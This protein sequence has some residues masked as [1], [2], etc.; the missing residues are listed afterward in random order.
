MPITLKE[1]RRKDYHKAIRFAI[2]GMHFE[3]YLDSKFLLNLYGTY[4][5]YDE[6]NNCT[7]CIAA[8]DGDELVGV[9]LTDMR[10]VEKKYRSLGKTV[11]TGIFDFL[12][13]TFFSGGVDVYNDANQE[14]F[15]AFTAQHEPDGQLIFLAADP[16]AKIKGIGTMLLNELDRREA[17][18]RIYLYTD[19][20]CTWQFYEHRGFDRVCEKDIVMDLQGKIVKLKCLLYSKEIGK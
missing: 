6:L 16:H 5:W 19:D 2:E 18:K 7:Q 15:R 17:G 13:K 20:A 3:M 12:Q 4:F 11:F 14:M 8:Y 1:I 9:L 10:G